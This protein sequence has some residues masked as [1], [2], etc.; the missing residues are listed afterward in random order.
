MPFSACS[1]GTVTSC[2]TSE[3]DSPTQAVWITTRGGANSGKTSTLVSCSEP[4]PITVTA[5]PAAATR[6]RKRRLLA[7][8]QRI[9]VRRCAV[10]VDTV[11]SSPAIWYSAPSSS[12][13][14]RTTTGVPAGGPEVRYAVSPWI[15]AIPMAA[16]T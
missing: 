13:A 10:G 2:S 3:V 11:Y 4:T 15:D 8:T 5:R 16:R 14:P 1:S 7:T 6:Y 9:S 12:G